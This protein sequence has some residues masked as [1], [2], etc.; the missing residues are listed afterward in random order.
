[1]IEHG[2]WLV[3][4]CEDWS[5]FFQSC[6]WYTFRFC[7]IE[8]ENDTSLGGV[9]ATIVLLG[10]GFRWRWNHT[11]TETMAQILQ[12]VDDIKSGRVTPI[13]VERPTST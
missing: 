11:R 12:D 9:E 10:I 13:P 4:F 6:N 7:M 8:F 5:Q 2:N 1:M 3:E